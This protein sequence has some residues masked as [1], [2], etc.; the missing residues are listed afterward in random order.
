MLYDY[1][2]CV[3]KTV[4]VI[5]DISSVTIITKNSTFATPIMHL[6]PGRLKQCQCSSD[7]LRMLIGYIQLLQPTRIWKREVYA[8]FA[9]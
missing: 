8:D 7:L 9:E 5:S 3:R 6:L 1:V 2:R 4:E